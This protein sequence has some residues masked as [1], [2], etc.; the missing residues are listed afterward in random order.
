MDIRTYPLNNEMYSNKMIT[1]AALRSLAEHLDCDSNE[2]I[3]IITFLIRFNIE[4]FCNDLKKV[5]TYS[6]FR[7]PIKEGYFPKMDSQVASRAWPPR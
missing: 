7:G 6:D 4:R 2:F 5:E 3:K 1:E